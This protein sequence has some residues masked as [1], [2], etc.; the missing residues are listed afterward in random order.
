MYAFSATS[1]GSLFLKVTR[2]F[3]STTDSLDVSLPLPKRPCHVTVDVGCS[4]F[5]HD[6]KS[7]NPLLVPFKVTVENRANASARLHFKADKD[8]WVPKGVSLPLLAL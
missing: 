6:F 1:V 4:K 8:W 2:L 7:G 3:C 5:W